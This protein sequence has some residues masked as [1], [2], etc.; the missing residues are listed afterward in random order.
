MSVGDFSSLK[1]QNSKNP[2]I[3]IL[4][5][6]INSRPRML[7]H[8]WKVPKRNPDLVP[9][10]SSET[11]SDVIIQIQRKHQ[12][13]CPNTCPIFNARSRSFVQASTKIVRGST[14]HCPSYSRSRTTKR[15]ID[16]IIFTKFNVYKYNRRFNLT[17]TDFEFIWRVQNI[18]KNQR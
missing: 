6:Y 4:C 7:V 8:I 9:N 5:I 11:F 17:W 14:G 3:R 2:F 16:F 10:G 13:K 1:I 15:E 12:I 18:T